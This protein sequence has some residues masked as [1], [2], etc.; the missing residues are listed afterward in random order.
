[1]KKTFTTISIVLIIIGVMGVALNQLFGYNTVSYLSSIRIEE[2][3][4]WVY[5]YDL[6]T[7]IKNIQTAMN[8]TTMLELRLP[9]RTWYTTMDLT[10]WPDRLANNLALILDYFI[11]FLNVFLYPL[12]VGAYSC[13]MALSIMGVNIMDS[14]ETNPIYWIIDLINKL[15]QIQIPYV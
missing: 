2:T 3:D 15:I 6:Q 5:Q 11:M 12:R 4:V 14:T 10:N 1:M 8:E 9:W 7:Y 13:K